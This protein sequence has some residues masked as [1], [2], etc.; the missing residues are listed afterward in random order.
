ML[1]PSCSVAPAFGTLA[2]KDLAFA[3]GSETD[4]SRHLTENAMASAQAIISHPVALKR[5]VARIEVFLSKLAVDSLLATVGW[6][7][8][9][10][11]GSNL[12]GQTACSDL[13]C[14]GKL[15]GVLRNFSWLSTVPA[16]WLD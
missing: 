1:S 8:M 14:C 12:L 15:I 7:T 2:L 16:L 6:S 3:P 10:Q 4:F 5:M 13:G 11:Q 9:K